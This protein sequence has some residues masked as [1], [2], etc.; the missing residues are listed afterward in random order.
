M[1]QTAS[2]AVALF[3]LT[4]LLAALAYL[5]TAAPGVFTLDSPELTVGA[6]S[7]GIVHAPGYPVFM[8]VGHLFLKLPLGDVGLRMNLLSALAAAAAAGIIT[9][10]VW[11]LTERR[12]AGVVAG[13]AFA[14]CYYVWSMA[15]IAEVYTFQ[16]LLLVGTLA[17]LWQWRHR[18]SFAS[19]ALA[20]LLAGLAAAN[21]PS[22]VLWWPGYLVLA[23]ATDARR[24]LRLRHFAALCGVLLLGLSALLY[25]PLRSLAEPAFVYVGSYDAAG[26]FNAM[27]LSRLEN[28]V[29]YLSGRQFSWLVAPYTAAELAR[30]AGRTVGWLWAGFLGVGL[31]LGLWGLWT[32]Y[33]RERFLALGLALAALPHTLFFIA[34]GAPDKETMFLPLFAVWAIFLGAGLAQLQSMLPQQ[35]RPALLALPLALLLVNLSY[36]DVSDFRAPQEN[37]VSRLVRADPGAVVLAHWGDAGAMHYQQLVNGLRV[38]VSVI[39]VFFISPE[40]LNTLIDDS[41]AEGRAVYATYSSGLPLDRVRL[42]SIGSDFQLTPRPPATNLSVRNPILQQRSKQ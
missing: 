15:V 3:G 36:V 16:A 35:G 28:L 38:D 5:R 14:L 31:P 23:V 9:L 18:A 30:E 20:A 10:M 19:L 1:R 37:S 25:L 8:L 40:D 26:Q 6:H 13:L 32:L 27:D 7:L 24:T 21:N 12:L 4:S 39:N 34:Y 29:W 2:N 33:R 17:L 42:A 41:L 22:T 11:W